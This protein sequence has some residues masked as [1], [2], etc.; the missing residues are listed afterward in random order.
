MGSTLG[1]D[2]TAVAKSS[3]PRP[4]LT[5]RDGESPRSH[6]VAKSLGS[7]RDVAMKSGIVFKGHFS[8]VALI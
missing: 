1:Y 4:T 8:V 6:F 2:T 5:K 7:R 3:S